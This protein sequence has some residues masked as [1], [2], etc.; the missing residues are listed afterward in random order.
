MIRSVSA[1]S[2]LVPGYDE[3]LAF[4]ERAL[5]F[6][7]ESDVLLD[8]GKRWVVVAPPGGAGAKIVLAVPGDER[9]RDRVGDQTGGRVGYFLVTDD[10]HK[11]YAARRAR[12]VTFLEEPR[13]ERYGTVAVFIDP[14]GGKWDLLQPVGVR[15][16]EAGSAP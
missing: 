7:V 12:G 1:I 11:D 3:G 8:G 14:W 16:E 2:L 13:Q 4:F 10:F 5:G 9:Q 6:T 15:G